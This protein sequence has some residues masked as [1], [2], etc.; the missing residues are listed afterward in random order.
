MENLIAKALEELGSEKTPDESTAE[1]ELRLQQFKIFLLGIG[2]G[3]R[4]KEI[5]SLLW[6]QIEFDVCEI[7][8]EANEHYGLKSDSSSATV[9]IDQEIAKL[10]ETLY[11][12]SKGEFVVESRHP[13]KPNASYSYIRAQV[14]FSGLYRWLRENGVADQKPLHALRK[15]YG[16]IINKNHGLFAAQCALRHADISTTANHYLDASERITPQI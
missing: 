3:L 7:R 16:S 9:P 6:T 13:P 4:R 11:H 1:F 2:A 10:L 14:A 5:D 8:L 12:S 15:E